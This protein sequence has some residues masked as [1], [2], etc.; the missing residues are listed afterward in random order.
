MSTCDTCKWWGDVKEGHIWRYCHI[1][2]SDEFD[3]EEDDA[4]VVY[5]EPFNSGTFATGPKFGCIHHEPK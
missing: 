3:M 2:T 5:G 1:C 4:G